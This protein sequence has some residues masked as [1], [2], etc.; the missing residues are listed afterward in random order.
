MLALTKLHFPTLTHSPAI[1][2][3]ASIL[4][5]SK[6]LKM[7]VVRSIN[8]RWLSLP[9]QAVDAKIWLLLMPKPCAGPGHQ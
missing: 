9:D 6:L 5:G 4:R 1:T 7:L 8:T 2:A 3:S